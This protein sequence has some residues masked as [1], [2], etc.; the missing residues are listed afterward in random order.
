MDKFLRQLAER[1]LIYDAD[2][3]TADETR[4]W[5]EGKLDELLSQ[6]ILSEIQHASGVIC[7]QCEDGCYIEP[8]IRMHPTGE[9]V[10]VYTCTRN[11]DIGR[12]D[13]NLDRLRQWKINKEKLKEL[14]FFKK[15]IKKRK[16]KVSSELTPK[17]TEVFTLIHV[18]NKTQQQAAIEMS[19]T[20]Q[21][22]SKL[23]KKAEA[24]I[25]AKNSRSINLKQAQNLPKDRRGQIN[26]P[27]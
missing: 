15:K 7:D 16:R 10:G 9:T 14:G 1:L 26:I 4:E 2:I 25:K 20:P 18:Q 13:V 19:C 23:L 17:E 3:I 5:P 8:D 27:S 6:E 24:K 22:I 11:P 21:N 12:I